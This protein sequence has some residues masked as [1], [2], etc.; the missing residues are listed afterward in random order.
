MAD[1]SDAM[2]SHGSC[3]VKLT[4]EMAT[5]TTHTIRPGISGELFKRKEKRFKWK[6]KG[7]IA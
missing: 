5:R 3:A 1:T 7:F 2:M 6:E 4:R